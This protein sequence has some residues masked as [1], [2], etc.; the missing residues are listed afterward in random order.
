MTHH[1]MKEYLYW[2]NSKMCQKGK[3]ALLLMDNFSAHSLAVEQ[4]EE[5]G[6]LTMT[7]VWLFLK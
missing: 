1:I 7:K 2:F 5:K 3:K 4:M 6:E